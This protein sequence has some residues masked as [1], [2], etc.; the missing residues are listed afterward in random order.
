MEPPAAPAGETV[1]L[2][3]GVA[4]L[5]TL[6]DGRVFP[7]LDAL[8]RRERLQRWLSRKARA[9]RNR[10]KARGRVARLHWHIA[11]GRRDHLHKIS[12]TLSKN[13]NRI[14]LEDLAVR[15]MTGSAR[16][17]HAAPGRNV[18]QK[19]RLNRSI[20]EQGWGEFRRQLE[21]KTKWR[22]GEV[23]V[24]LPAYTSRTC[25]QCGQVAKENRPSQ[26]RFVCVAGGHDGVAA[27]NI[28]GAGLALSACGRN[29][30]VS[31]AARRPSRRILGL[32]AGEK[33]KCAR[34]VL[35]S[36]SGLR[37][38]SNSPT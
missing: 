27:R 35:G 15:A 12:C 36:L 25:P 13:H 31:A 34:P 18:R 21:Y 32:Q 37:P 33:V 28:L 24:V 29:P 8:R 7:A 6:S 10:A 3:L 1:A 4:R 14:V 38:E 23:I 11:N 5:A 26:A 9:S 30:P 16:G 20:L 2:D 19:A 17:T 22:G